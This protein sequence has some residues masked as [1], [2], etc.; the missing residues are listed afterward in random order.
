MYIG[1]K[2][3]NTP[4]VEIGQVAT[5]FYFIWFTVI[6]PFIGLTE[7][8][9]LNAPYK[10]LYLTFSIYQKEFFILKDISGVLNVSIKNIKCNKDRNG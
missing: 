4:F 9:E 3:P 8:K 7:N 6:I 2:H 1:S 10:T 5:A